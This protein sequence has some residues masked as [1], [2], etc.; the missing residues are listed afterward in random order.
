MAYDGLAMAAITHEL[1]SLLDARVEK[2]YQPAAAVLLISL[3]HQQ[4]GR[5]KLLISAN[6]SG[7]RVHLTEGKWTNPAA[8]PMFCMLLRKHLEG[9]RLI[10]VEQYGLERLLTLSFNGRDDLGNTVTYR[11]IA[12]I[13]GRHS[14][15][16]LVSQEDKILDSIIRVPP[17]MSSVR[18]VLPGLTYAYP[19]HQD[20]LDTL[21]VQN[22]EQLAA[23]LNSEPT[24][25]L[26]KALVAKLTGISPLLSNE[27]LHRANLAPKQAVAE[28]PATGWNRLCQELT[29]LQIM[30]RNA[31]FRPSKSGKHFAALL[32]THLPA[33]TWP[34][35]MN[36][37]VDFVFTETAAAASIQKQKQQLSSVIRQLLQKNRRKQAN[38]AEE[39]TGIQQ[40]L[41]MRRKGELI[42]SSLHLIAPKAESA[43]VIDYYD[44]EMPEVE[45]S[46]NPQLTGTQNAQRCFRRYERARRGIPIVEKNLAATKAEIAYLESLV[47]SIERA[48]QTALLTEIEQEMRQTGLLTQPVKSKK[49]PV[50]SPSEPLRFASPD[51]AEILV[52]R[53]N[54]QNER[55]TKSASP[56]DWWLHTKDIPG[57]HVLVRGAGAEMSAATLELAAGL[58][59]YFSK[60]RQSSKVPVD[61]TL[62]KHVKKPSGSPPGFVIY[63]DQ[64]T[65]LIEPKMPDTMNAEE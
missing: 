51:G 13:M 4:Q 44:P 64:Q 41:S 1:T 39:L 50:S 65:V 48:D 23:V 47:D 52:G 35:S 15:I 14:N 34:S 55:L 21:A 43:K 62:R 57:S 36:E 59:A 20:R 9:S 18:M 63:T 38:Q 29:E 37:L 26:N 7:P 53:N 3:H 32:L 5:C 46:L 27:L 25:T 2:I 16:L 56:D 45:V 19:V 40:D 28:V 12:E 17:A 6:P 8:P 49:A 61:Y 22:S 24:A 58:A 33:E 31:T 42:V 54:L 11:L 60:S 10:A 30:V